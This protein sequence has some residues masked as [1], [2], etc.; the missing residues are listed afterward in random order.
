MGC[1]KHL[2][3]T[4]LGTFPVDTSKTRL[5]LQGQHID[6]K[7]TELRYRGMIHALSRIFQEEGIKALYSGLVLAEHLSLCFPFSK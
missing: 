5:Q 1:Y 2:F 4:F 7:F 6:A 3:L